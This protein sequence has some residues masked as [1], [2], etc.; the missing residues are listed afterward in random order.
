MD[1]HDGDTVWLAWATAADGKGEPAA[2]VNSG[3]VLSAEHRIAKTAGV[4]RAIH[5]FERACDS[6][7]EAWQ[8]C[9][10]ILA[11]FVGTINEKIDECGRRAAQ[12]QVGKA[13]PQ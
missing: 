9:A 1:L 8:A 3:T 13:V 6:E 4:A 7:A 11:G 10:A 12:L 5:S 2:F